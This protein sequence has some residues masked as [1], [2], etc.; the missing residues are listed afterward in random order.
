MFLDS[1]LGYFTNDISI[2]LGTANTLIYVK[3]RGIVLNE[4]SVAA[5]DKATGKVIAV[6]IE[7]KGMLGRTP[8]EIVA[9]RPLKEGVIADFETAE[10]LLREL[11][12]KVQKRRLFIRPRIMIAVPSGITE[13][14]KRAVRDS[15]AAAGAREVYLVA[16]PVAAAIGVGLPINKPAGNM[17]IDMGGGTTEIAVIAL[18]GIVTSTSIRV[19]GDKLD[20][21]II[22]FVKRTFNLLIGDQTAEQIKMRIGSAYDLGVEEEMEIKGRDLVSGVPKTMTIKSSQVREA[23]QE[24][25]AAI[26][27]AVRRSLESTPPELAA[28]IVDRGIVL[29][30][31]GALLRGLDALLREETNLP[32]NL[33]EDPLTAVVLGTGK[34]LDEP[35]NFEKV[36]MK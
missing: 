18:F 35:E 1:L 30:G 9:I 19:G 10:A 25:I 4:P 29:T 27:D 6:G 31:G 11:I 36:L 12:Q 23:M 28:D 15:A 16:E 3:G 34:I 26:V 13:V 17:V 22:Q 8:G 32:I 33:V 7:A 5:L 24:P 21:A 2:D 14:E 20:E